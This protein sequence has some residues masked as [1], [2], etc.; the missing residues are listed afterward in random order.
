MSNERLEPPTDLIEQAAQALRATPIPPGPPAEAI[1]A[2]LA[3]PADHITVKQSATLRERIHIMKPLWKLAAAILIAAGLVGFGYLLL[4]GGGAGTQSLA[5][6][7]VVEPLLQ[8]QTGTY[9]M[10]IRMNGIPEQTLTG[11]FKEPG[12]IRHE[13]TVVGTISMT[14]I[15]DVQQGKMVQLMPQQNLAMVMEMR[16]LPEKEKNINDL[17][18]Y[19]LRA[20][21]QKAKDD[22]Q[23]LVEELGEQTLESTPVIGYRIKQRELFEMTVTIWADALTHLPVQMQIT[24]GEF[25]A[26]MGPM[27]LVI[28][29]FQFNM[30]LADSLFSL[31]VPDGF[32]VYNMEMDLSEPDEETLVEA[33]RTAAE[34]TGG[35]FPGSLD[36]KGMMGIFRHLHQLAKKDVLAIDPKTGLPSEQDLQRIINKSIPLVMAIMFVQ[37]LPP[38]CDWHYAG[39]GVT[40]AMPDT[41]IFWYRPVGASTYRVIYGDL[42]VEECLPQD[43][44]VAPEPEKKKGVLN[45]LLD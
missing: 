30:P 20:F 10:H 43:V 14:Q 22:P 2:V 23:Q 13:I 27:E 7:K 4:P 18:L 35:Q 44:P 11:M 37:Q 26:G 19:N 16:N 42:Q 41:A 33:L 25:A 29:D 24:M 45:L 12:R 39:K 34:I 36:F 28:D 6:A 21:I 5:F 31:E 3:A 32:V 15:I 38:E 9:R 17:N 40:T 8:A 1:R